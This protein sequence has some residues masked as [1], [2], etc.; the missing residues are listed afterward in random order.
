MLLDEMNPECLTIL[1]TYQCNAAC[2]ECCFESNPSIKHRMS[3]KEL[4]SIIR[5]IPTELPKVKYVV[6]S[7][8]EV[9]LLKED[10]IDAISLLT[11]LGLGS[12]IVTNGHWGRSDSSAEKWI[13]NLKGAGL[14]EL[15][16]STGDEHQ[17]F[18]PFDSVARCANH[19]VKT[20]LLTVIVREGQDHS[21]FK[22]EDLQSHPLISEICGSSNLKK[23]LLLMNNVWMPFH[24]EANITS[25][26]NEVV[27]EGCDNIFDNFVV[28]PYG[29][30]L[31]CCGL[32]MEYISDLTVG[33]IDT[34]NLNNTYVSQFRD[35][36]K[37]WIWLDGTRYIFDKAIQ[38]SQSLISVEPA[39]P[40][41]CSICAQIHNDSA[42]RAIVDEMVKEGSEDI[43]FRA[44]IKA[45]TVV[46][47]LNIDS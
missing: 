44:I 42:I 23:W 18:I 30:L 9:T 31:V 7:G 3:R 36:L 17:E 27:Y 16:L 28:N 45:K 24:T 39:S 29:N 26:K 22:M 14:D 21:N 8:G 5:R 4:L 13:S 43:I 40:H 37:L 6:L 11:E 41:P 12:R 35:I 1:P 33:N 32:T 47:T 19:A 25:E 34:D 20:Q 15:N 46:N 10:L 2:A 38:K